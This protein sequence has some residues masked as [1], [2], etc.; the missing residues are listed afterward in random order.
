MNRT[1]PLPDERRLRFERALLKHEGVTLDG[2]TELRGGYRTHALLLGD[3]ATIARIPRYDEAARDLALEVRVLPVLESAGLPFGTPGQARALVD[4]GGVVG[5]LHTAVPG[6]LSDQVSNATTEARRAFVSDLVA[7]VSAMHAIPRARFDGLAPA[8][9]RDERFDRWAGAARPQLSE[10]AAAWVE[11]RRSRLRSI[12]RPASIPAVFA[13]CDLWGSNTLVGAD[14]RLTGVIDFGDA[15]LTDPAYDLFAFRE[16]FGDEG[17]AL[18]FERYAGPLDDHAPE[19]SEIYRDM[20]ELYDLAFHV[21]HGLPY[22]GELAVIES[23]AAAWAGE[24]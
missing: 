24:A 9:A 13:H 4:E 18:A 21:E 7:F 19:R 22:D 14:Q 6:D 16:R 15:M 10:R 17:A 3:G 2:A 23:R 12:E 20:D 1:T 8:D 5:T 11:A